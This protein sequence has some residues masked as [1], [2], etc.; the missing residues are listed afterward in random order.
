M[1]KPPPGGPLFSLLGAPQSWKNESSKQLAYTILQKTV[2]LL[3]SINARIFIYSSWSIT[4]YFPS[5]KI[6]FSYGQS[7][8]MMKTTR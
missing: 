4:Y 5:Q 7:V 6:S 8:K 3:P 2:W 1:T